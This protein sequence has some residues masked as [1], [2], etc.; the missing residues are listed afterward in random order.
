MSASGKYH[1]V[2]VE[3]LEARKRHRMLIE[4][5]LNNYNLSPERRA[6]LKQEL[7]KALNYEAKARE[8]EQNEEELEE[9]EKK[10]KGDSTDGGDQ[11][12]RMGGAGEGSGNT[13]NQENKTLNT[14]FSN[15]D[16]LELLFF[17]EEVDV[18]VTFSDDYDVQDAFAAA[19]LS[20]DKQEQVAQLQEPLVVGIDNTI[21]SADV[22]L[23]S[24]ESHAASMGA[25]EMYLKVH[26]DAVE[27]LKSKFGYE[28]FGQK[29]VSGDVTL[30][31]MRKVLSQRP[32]L[33]N[34][35]NC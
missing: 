16:L 33:K 20:F 26:P 27:K 28:T 35:F 13:D 9:E 25:R 8:D 11:Q 19:T 29:L 15:V 1:I 5:A 32:L 34:E 30:L 7:E 31:R 23:Q 24:L 4:Q 14:E 18:P 6:R 21:Y 17:L 10:K 12:G 22:F 3:T 2:L